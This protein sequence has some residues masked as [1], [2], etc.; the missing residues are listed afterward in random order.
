[1]VMNVKGKWDK[2]RVKV[3]NKEGS[4]FDRIGEPEHC[5]QSPFLKQFGL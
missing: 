1:M 2:G 3:M 4:Q 5:L